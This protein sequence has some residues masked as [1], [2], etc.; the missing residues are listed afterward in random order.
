MS[1]KLISKVFAKGPAFVGYLTAGDGGLD[2]SFEAALALIQGGVDILEIGVPFSDPVAD[3]PV[4]QR[5]MQRALQNN[6]TVFDALNLAKKIKAHCP[7]V[8]LILFGYF[9]PILVAQAKGFFSIAQTSGVDAMLTVDLPLGE[10]ADYQQ[11]CQQ[12]AIDPI[13]L[14]TPA[15]TEQR[16]I[17]IDKNSAAFLYYV[18]TRGTTGI[19]D[20]LPE[21][22]SENLAHVKKISAN[23]VVAGI[24]ISNKRSA[25]TVLKHAN[26][27]VV[28]SAIVRAM[29][30]KAMPT[31]LTKLIRQIDPR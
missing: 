27:F 2:Y 5:A 9:N 24:G 23:P 28:G 7:T 4:I 3:G 26:G 16:I 31:E 8:P 17:D 22:V 13:F 14:I 10:D 1:N 25:Q 30:E 21:D 12:H 15:T 19:R 20:K 29:E 11:Q 18:C 6:T